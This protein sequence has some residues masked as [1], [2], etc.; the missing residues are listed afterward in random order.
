VQSILL[1]DGHVGKVGEV[2]RGALERLGADYEVV[3]A[4]GCIVIP[5]LIDPHS[6]LLGGSGETGYS[7]QTPEFFI[8]EIIPF[9]ITTVVGTLGVD[10][11]M[12]TMP[13]LLAKVKALKEQGIN[14]YCWTGG[15]DV[16]PTSILGTVREDI[17]FIEEVIGAGEVA[18]S[19]ER[20]LAP[21]PAGLA[22]TA[23]HAH[24]GGMLAKKA[25]LVH[26]HVGESERRLS[27]LREVLENFDVKPSWFYATHI[28]RTEKL[29]D[30]A[31]ELSNQGM[32]CDMDVVEADLH[33]WVRYWL[34]H[35]GS[36]ERLTVSSDASMTG[37]GLVWNQVR[38]CVLK[39]GFT[40]EQM[41][42]L[43]TRNTGRILKLARKGEIRKTF[44]GDLVMLDEGSLEI[45][46]VMAQGKMMVR[47]GKLME[48]ENWL[49]DSDR[50]IHLSGRKNEGGDD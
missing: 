13:G 23:T 6:H 24:V 16:P 18:I 25:G 17:M 20:A 11:T 15:Y 28:E 8:S 3:D 12:K 4:T 49:K 41:L 45:V 14:A 42:P 27:P 31:I 10:T 9:G 39:H 29:V 36:P 35:G 48:Q 22:R 2:D 30:E 5:G 26:V 46:N 37:H 21:D 7:T 1:A 44:V 38:E 34:D 43:V 19:D 40:L 47:D 32:P 33:R 50:E